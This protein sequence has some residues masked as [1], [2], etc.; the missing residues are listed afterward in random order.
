M[1][2]NQSHLYVQVNGRPMQESS[3]QKKNIALTVSGNTV[4]I[5][6]DN[7]LQLSFNAVNDLTM[8]ISADLA[9]KVC[10]AC[11]CLKPVRSTE[12]I[13]LPLGLGGWATIIDIGQWRA[14][15]FPQW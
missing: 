4:A 11:G 5:K 13:S 15:D 14:P 12:L 8:S 2:A 9:E 3:F 10:G 1:I 7:S 6:R